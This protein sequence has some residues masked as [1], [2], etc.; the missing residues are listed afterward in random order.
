ML[1]VVL[2][3]AYQVRLCPCACGAVPQ[4]IGTLTLGGAAC[5]DDEMLV[6]QSG[7]A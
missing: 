3:H 1:V 2:G 5:E 6:H 4:C 7:D